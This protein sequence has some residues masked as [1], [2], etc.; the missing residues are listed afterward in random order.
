MIWSAGDLSIEID[1]GISRTGSVL[2]RKTNREWHDYLVDGE[3]V[4][5]PFDIESYLP[6]YYRLREK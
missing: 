1:F 4:A 6:G 2:Q 3:P 5:N